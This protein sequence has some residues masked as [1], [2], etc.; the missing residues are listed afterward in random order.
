MAKSKTGEPSPVIIVRRPTAGTRRTTAAAGR[1]YADFVTA[2][3]AF[4]CFCGFGHRSSRAEKR[5]FPGLSGQETCPPRKG[6]QPGEDSLPYGQGRQDRPS[7]FKLSQ[8]NKLSTK[9]AL[10]IKEMITKRFQ[11]APR[12]PGSARFLGCAFERQQPRALRIPTPPP[13]NRGGEDP[14]GR[15]RGPQGPQ[16]RPGGPGPRDDGETGGGAYPSKGELSSA[17]AAAIVR[18]IVEKGGI[19]PTRVR[20]VGYGDSQPLV[21]PTSPDARAKNRRVEF[22]Y[23]GQDTPAW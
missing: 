23:H 13:S 14:P 20:A 17:R 21:P 7:R 16:A 19:P 6:G 22:Y 3:M 5:T 18:H 11:P 8:G 12:I 10:M 2:M 9:W 1:C 4:S 15:G